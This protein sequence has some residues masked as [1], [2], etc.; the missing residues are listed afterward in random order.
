MASARAPGMTLAAVRSMLFPRLCKTLVRDGALTL[1]DADGTT[2]RS[3]E[4]NRAA[5]VVVRLHD[6]SLHYKLALDP[7]FY[8]GEAYVNGALTVER[9]DVYELLDLCTR[10]LARLRARPETRWMRAL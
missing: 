1:I 10:S 6:P 4:A 3:G 8:L 9:G 7:Y 2:Y 5:D